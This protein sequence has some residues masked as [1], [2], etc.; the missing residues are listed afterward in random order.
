MASRGRGES[1]AKKRLNAKKRRE[2]CNE[3]D[4][5][6]DIGI[7]EATASAPH[8]SQIRSIGFGCLTDHR[9]II[10]PTVCVDFLFDLGK[11]IPCHFAQ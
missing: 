5:N 7:A 1:L 8:A 9:S 2:S 11:G 3:N 4:S 10:H 6:D